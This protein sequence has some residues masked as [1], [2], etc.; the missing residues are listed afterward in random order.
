MNLS[1]KTINVITL[2]P[3]CFTSFLNTSIVKRAIDKQH[4]VINVI[5]IRQF[6]SDKQVDDYA[7]GGGGMVLKIAPI[8]VALKSIAAP[9]HIILLAADGKT[10]VQKTA[11]KLLKL[12]KSLTLICGHYE[13]IDH[14]IKHFIDEEI[15]IG[16]YVLSGGE[17]ASMVMIDAIVR[18]I[19]GVINQNSLM[20]ESFNDNHL[21][22]FPVFTKPDNFEGF[23]IP[24]IL[25]NGNH[26]HIVEWRAIKSL[27]NTF[28]KRYNLIKKA[29]L[30][31]VQQL[32][33][34]K[35]KMAK[36]VKT[37]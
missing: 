36:H 18:L 9:T 24:E 8:V 1:K 17:V 5:D 33:L 22:D 20:N 15:S 13:G 16:D 11:V 10:F 14:R 2:F 4:C 3:D 34:A 28:Y 27:E 7:A 23:C 37:D 35:L 29:K 31:N 21:L 25:K 19:P 26:A 30:S 6:A 32:H 12:P